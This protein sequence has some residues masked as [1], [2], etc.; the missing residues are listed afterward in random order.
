MRLSKG[1]CRA[2]ICASGQA[3]AT[4]LVLL[5]QLM[6][7]IAYVCHVP[8]WLPSDELAHMNNVL[9]VE[10]TGRL[11]VLMLADPDYEAVQPPLYYVA[12]AIICKICRPLQLEFSTKIKVVRV[13]NVVLFVLASFVFA[14]SLQLL[15]PG[16]E[17]SN[18]KLAALS[19]YALCPSLLAIAASVT[20]DSCSYLLSSLSAHLLIRARK[21]SWGSVDTL[22]LSG[23]NGLALLTKLAFFPA[24][25][26]NAGLLLYDQRQAFN[27]KKMSTLFFLAI[28]S[29]ILLVPWLIWNIS[30]YGT[31]TGISKLYGYGSQYLWQLNNFHLTLS[32]FY[33]QGASFL[34]YHFFPFEFW[35]NVLKTPVVFKLIE[36]LLFNMATYF[37]V[38]LCLKRRELTAEIRF[39]CCTLGTLYLT[40]TVCWAAVLLFFCIEPIRGFLGSY[41]GFAFLIAAG[42][43]QFTKRR[44][45]LAAW[46]LWFLFSNLW[47]LLSPTASL[48]DL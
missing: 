20:N 37:T 9:N 35:K 16:D 6:L 31:L 4:I 25:I 26:A 44:W 34:T 36:I 46:P 23:I 48:P 21:S 17:H 30:N 11:H 33:I 8:L 24:V 14:Q 2:N 43:A 27:T 39:A 45:L 7:G 1:S 38:L 29:A 32:D 28:P 10:N 5:T 22:R 15:L 42:T 19:I 13:I 3:R 47:L 41:F 18:I 40:S 12:S